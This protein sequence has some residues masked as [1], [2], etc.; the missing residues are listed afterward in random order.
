[1]NKL[2]QPHLAKINNRVV[3]RKRTWLGLYR[4][5]DHVDNTWSFTMWR[6]Y[7]TVEAAREARARALRQL[8][9]SKPTYLEPL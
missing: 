5:Y 3:I 4:Y 8:D 9:V 2:H 6:D 7:A 1:M